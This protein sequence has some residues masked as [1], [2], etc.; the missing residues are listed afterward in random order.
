M[1][2]SRRTFIGGLVGA[3]VGGCLIGRD[4]CRVYQEQ[5][6]LRKVLLVG[7]DGLRPDALVKTA[8]P[9]LDS[10]MN[11]GAYSL[12]ARTGVHTLSGPGWSNILTG[13][14]ENKHGVKDNSF[15][16][17]NYGDYPTIFNRLESHKP[18]LYTYSV[19][20]LS[21]I[22]DIII[23]KADYRIYHPFEEEGDLKV[24]ETASAVLSHHNVDLM[25]AYLM[26]VDMA[27]HQ[28]GFDPEV[29]EYLSEIETIDHYVG[30][31]MEALKKRPLYNKEQWLTILTSDHG[32]K[33]KHHDGVGEEAMKVPLIIHGSAVQKGEIVPVPRQ[34][35]IAPTIL[36]YLGIPIKEE[37]GLDGKVVGLKESYIRP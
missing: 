16:G 9:N 7:V 30:M 26:G 10:L 12:E 34:V 37:W 33:G 18:T 27:G 6:L 20:S 29:P 11:E 35:D 8:T 23:T 17:A 36:N 13:V 1:S 5:S 21:W 2:L 31:L 19:A 3:G 22:N 24:A 15:E 25:F 28:H 32:G 14:W 4:L